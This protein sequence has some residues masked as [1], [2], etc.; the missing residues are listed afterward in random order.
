MPTDGNP[1]L[2]QFIN[3]LC[4]THFCHVPCRYGRGLLREW[5]NTS[6]VP[7]SFKS[8]GVHVKPVMKL[9]LSCISQV[10]FYDIFHKK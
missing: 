4:C 5:I 2:R 7:A 10:K 6:E 1:M 3:S 8:R 9:C